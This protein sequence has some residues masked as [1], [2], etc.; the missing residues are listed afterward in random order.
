MKIFAELAI[1]LVGA[2][3][4]VSCEDLPPPPPYEYH[5]HG[6][7]AHMGRLDNSLELNHESRFKPVDPEQL[8]YQQQLNEQDGPY[9]FNNNGDQQ[10]MMP[11]EPQQQQANG[12]KNHLRNR[13]TG[14]LRDLTKGGEQR[15]MAIKNI[16]ADLMEVTNRV[17]N[18][19]TVVKGMIKAKPHLE[20]MRM[21]TQ[22]LLN[23]IN[24]RI[25]SMRSHRSKNEAGETIQMSPMPEPVN[26][27]PVPPPNHM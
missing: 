23:K 26:V 16:Q 19:P 8:Y 20:S 14:H 2:V 1:L 4:F 9:H 13:I 11:Q 27:Y 17:K 22:P 15:G 6:A 5:A 12:P 10:Y 24:S 7:P 25:A 3:L 18:H 21:K